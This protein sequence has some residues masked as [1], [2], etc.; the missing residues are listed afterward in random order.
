MSSI[1]ELSILL[2]RSIIEHTHT[3]TESIGKTFFMMEVV[4]INHVDQQATLY[5]NGSGF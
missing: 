1:I 2:D 5:D 4:T 3:Y